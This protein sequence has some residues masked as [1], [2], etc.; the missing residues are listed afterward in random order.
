VKAVCFAAVVFV[1]LTL[2]PV[3]A[4]VHTV[5]G[6]GTPR[7]TSAPTNDPFG[8]ALEPD[9]ALYFC[10]MEGQRVRRLDFTT[11]LVTALRAMAS[12]RIE[13][14]DFRQSTR[15]STCGSDAGPADGYH[16]LGTGWRGM[17]RKSDPLHFG[18]HAGLDC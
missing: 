9:G 7:H 5:F 17:G 2:P 18:S 12:S 14:T 16:Q 3:A 13:A 11:G 6:T 10:E 8:L 15:R 1:S 4:S